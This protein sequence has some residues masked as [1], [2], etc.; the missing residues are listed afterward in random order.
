MS[1][2]IRDRLARDH[3]IAR[4]LHRIHEQSKHLKEL[5]EN[6]E[7]RNTEVHS[8]SIGD[9]FDKFYKELNEIKTF[10]RKYPN[11]PV[12]NLER[13]Y[14]RRPPAE[15]ESSTAEV[16]NMFTGEEAWGR[17]FD[18][19][20]FHEDYLNLPG[21][22]RLSYL[23]YLD[24]FFIFTPP[25][26]PIK[27]E[28]KR[29][30]RYFD[31]VGRLALYLEEFMRRTRPLE[32]VDKTFAAY[33]REFDKLW[34]ADGLP[35]WQAEALVG[36]AVPG[37][38]STEGVW[39]ADCRKEFKNENVYNA[40]LAG[41]KHIKA[42]QAKESSITA[43]KTTTD[44]PD[45][46][47]ERAIANREY[48]ISSL[49][50]VLSSV[51]SATRINVERR[52]GMTERERQQELDALFAESNDFVP[53]GGGD[54]DDGSDS[55]EKIYNPLKLPLAWDGKRQHSSLLHKPDTKHLCSYS[56]LVI[57][58]ARPWSRIF[59]RD[60]RQFRLYGPTRFR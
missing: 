50:S 22:K 33:G 58:T 51:R 37:A 11:E 19:T 31:Y 14:K 45:R 18:L 29:T 55:E 5:Y 12:E 7:A 27:R 21:V 41:K 30:D 35:A 3:Q 16:D 24:T 43:E 2:Q 57:Q 1:L 26:C 39:C 10:H 13:A 9:P 60:L 28:N 42:A 54:S 8:I 6:T 56:L 47:K 34:K 32:D 49:A 53:A 40:H 17:F 46:L 52:Q 36:P 15:G 23:Q 48:R 44:S 38:E 20:A 59:M 25:Q 4:F